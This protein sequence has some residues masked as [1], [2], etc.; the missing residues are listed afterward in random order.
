[1]PDPTSAWLAILLVAGVTLASRI[2][3]PLLMA[4]VPRSP[5]VER[6]LQSLSLAVIAALV[7]SMLTHGGPREAAAVAVAAV[8]MAVLRRP[9]W[10]MA[11]G[12]ACA[13]AWTLCLGQIRSAA[14]P[15]RRPRG[16]GRPTAG[17]R[18]ARQ[19]RPRAPYAAAISPI[20]PGFRSRAMG[21]RI[22]PGR[23]RT[24][25]WP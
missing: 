22:R 14:R 11:A 23:G 2:S 1:V 17:G 16:H 8:V 7:A 20:S 18:V 4:R 3:G 10:A 9:I 13:A 15:E 25:A 24:Q 21:R 6:F 12:M 5:A 19:G